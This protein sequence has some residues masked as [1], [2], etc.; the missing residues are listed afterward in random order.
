MKIPNPVIYAVGDVLGNWYYSH[1]KLN[2]L[3]GENGFPGDP[4]AGNCIHKCQEWMKRANNDDDVDPLEL[5]GL[6]L[7]EFMNLDYDENT[8]WKD[9]FRR[10]KE[11]LAKNELAFEFNG[12]IVTLPSGSSA[13]LTLP[14]SSIVHNEP[15]KP[16]YLQNTESVSLSTTTN[17]PVI[18]LVTVN[19]KET[20]ALFDVFLGEGKTPVHK[21]IGGIT[22]N[23]LGIH[24]GQRIVNTV[25]E[26][27]AGGIGASQQRTQQAIKHWQPQAI[28]AVGIAFGLDETKQQIGDVLISTQI[29]D[30]DLGRLNE[31]GTLTPRGDKPGSADILRNRLRQTDVTQQRCCR[32]WPKFDFGLVLS[33]QKL[34]DNLDYRESLKLLFPEAIG[35]EMEGTGLYVSASE[36]KVDWIV[37]KA[38]CDWG[39]NKNQADKDAWQRLAAKNAARALKAAFDIGSLYSNEHNKNRDFYAK[40]PTVET[41]MLPSPASGLSAPVTGTKALE[42]WQK[43]LDFLLTEE[44]K[45][46]DADQKFSIQER[47]EE[48]RR[49]ILELGGQL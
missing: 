18:I 19:D 37:I 10:I 41:G 1:T 44:A 8:Q 22:Y 26:M 39:R 29:Q 45:T 33:G 43:K 21:T 27:G 5:L 42:I 11:V 25:S 3:F 40:L 12:Q 32:D 38:I 16:S 36:A 49:K 9:G 46:S 31:D 4:P 28:I 2:T 20:H 17:D 35:G 13:E 14:N 47:I 30:Y 24:G 6:V 34:L 48:A 15:T 23:E 7:L